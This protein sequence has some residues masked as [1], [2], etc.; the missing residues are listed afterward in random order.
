MNR[1]ANGVVADEPVPEMYPGGPL[2]RAA[3]IEEGADRPIALLRADLVFTGRRAIDTFVKVP[4][5]K[6]DVQVRWRRTVSARLLPILRWREL[7]IHHVDLGVG[8]T[9]A[10]WP[11][12]F[13]E[14]TLATE[15]PALARLDQEVRVP[16]L[17]RHEIL[18][19]LVGRSSRDDL[20]ALPSWP[21]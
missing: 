5:N 14:S 8:Y 6:L 4:T 13:V 9:P 16:D 12:V 19:W 3:A 1:F 2:A 15:L 17:Q 11:H 7:E 18:A 20:P 21:F 10:D